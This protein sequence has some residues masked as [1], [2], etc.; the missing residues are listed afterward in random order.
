MCVVICIVE[1]IDG[2]TLVMTI[3]HGQQ[4]APPPLHDVINVSPIPVSPLLARV[5]LQAFCSCVCCIQ[6]LA[7]SPCAL[8]YGTCW[9]RPCFIVTLHNLHFGYL[10]FKRWPF[11][12]PPETLKA[13]QP[14][15]LSND[16]F[17]TLKTSSLS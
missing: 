1:S 9:S 14:C 12:F 16:A 11:D 5:S 4:I 6:T 8:P 13:L 7:H 15:R 10:K 3:L 17:S 2:C